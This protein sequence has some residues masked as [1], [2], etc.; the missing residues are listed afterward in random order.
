MEQ[1]F[2]DC[3]NMPASQKFDELCQMIN[4]LCERIDN[5]EMTIRNN[6]GTRTNTNKTLESEET[7]HP[8]SSIDNQIKNP[9]QDTSL[10]NLNSNSEKVEF[11]NDNTRKLLFAG[12]PE[13]AGFDI[14][15]VTNDKGIRSLYCFELT[16]GKH[17]K[18]YP[19]QDKILRFQNS[20]SSLIE[21]VCEIEGDIKECTSL[22]I[23]ESNKGEVELQDDNYWFVTKKCH[24]T[25]NTL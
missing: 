13:G 7:L 8:I 14:N 6:I 9:S 24:V 18:Y 17:A 23:E 3:S 19:L 21:P 1:L 12:Q 10:N 16:D 22:L 5:L 4:R 25:C 20:P 2:E 11:P 15:S